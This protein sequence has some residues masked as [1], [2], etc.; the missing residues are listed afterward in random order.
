MQRSVVVA[1][2][3][4]LHARPAAMFVAEAAKQ[5]VPVT[6]AKNGS[7]GPLARKVIRVA[8]PLVISEAEARASSELMRRILAGL[9]QNAP[10]SPPA[11]AGVR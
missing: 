3:E 5:P 11:L 6:I 9:V 2:E 8:P 4:G 7:V 10:A 1:I